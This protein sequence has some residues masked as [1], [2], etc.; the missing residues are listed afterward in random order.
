MKTCTGLPGR[1]WWLVLVLLWPATG[2]TYECVLI[3]NSVNVIY[4]NVQTDARQSVGLRCTR[5]AD[6]TGLWY[7]RISA[8]LGNNRIGIPPYRSVRLPKGTQLSYSLNMQAGPIGD[9]YCYDNTWWIGFSVYGSS[10]YVTP[11]TIRG[12]TGT[13]LTQTRNFCLRLIGPVET[14]RMPDPGVYV[15]QI[16]FTVEFL[17]DNTADNTIEIHPPVTLS[18]PVFVTV[19]GECKVTRPGELRFDYR[20]F[21]RI[22]S[23]AEDWVGVACNDGIY[24]TAS[25]D[26][27][28]G[29]LLGLNYALSTISRTEGYSSG[30]EERVYIRGVIPAGQSGTCAGASC[31]ARQPHTITLTY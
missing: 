18:I 26:Q 21:N 4:R 6:E 29:T 30:R 17:G 19:V 5:R 24:W 8:D 27:S 1:F 16:R 15:D 23:V 9:N 7:Y 12:Q 31:S 2:W 22:D 11:F 3:G 14:D 13:E 10:T 20:S 25:L 28:S